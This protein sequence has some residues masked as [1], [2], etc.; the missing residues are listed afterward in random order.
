[1]GDYDGPLVYR[2]LIRLP[3][4]PHGSND[5]IL[6]DLSLTARIVIVEG[7]MRLDAGPL[8]SYQM[9]MQTLAYA[10][11]LCLKLELG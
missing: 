3:N 11:H 8:F 5:G 1:M 2:V 9:G 4:P 10:S 6:V 7:L